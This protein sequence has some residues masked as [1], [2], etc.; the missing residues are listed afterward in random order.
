MNLA[1][2]ARDAMPAGGKLIIE[3]SNVDCDEKYSSQHDTAVPGPHVMLAIT[4]NGCGMDE[5]TKAHM[6]EPF[7]T[8]KEF[9]KGTGLGLSTVYGI[10]KQSGGF[11]WVYTELGIGTTFKICFPTVRTVHETE[12]PSDNFEKIDNASETILIVEDDAG[13]LEVTHRSL[14]AVGYAI[15]SARN[16]EEAI[17]IAES[18]PGPIH[19]MVTDV[20]LPGINGAQLASQLSRL[21]P[22]MKVLFV[23]GYT[24][25]YIVRHGVLEPGLAFLQKPFSPKALNRKVGEML[26]APLPF[27]EPAAWKI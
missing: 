15:L 21:R 19:L 25:E 10:M 5:K 16:P 8:T 6:F 3:T 1:V 4:D 12:S 27:A 20:I 9:G 11:V 17:R 7:F 22:E 18:H 24:D 23:S 26:A 13:L 2:N 14:E